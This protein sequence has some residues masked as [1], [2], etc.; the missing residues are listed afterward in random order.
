MKKEDLENRI[1]LMDQQMQQTLANY[2][3]LQGGKEECLYW[4]KSLNDQEE[5][6]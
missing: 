6:S 1:K 5:V 4:L 3:M 2:N